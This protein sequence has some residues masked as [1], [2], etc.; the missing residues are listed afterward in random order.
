VKVL[1]GGAATKVEGILANANV[2]SARALA[3]GDES[4]GV[5]DGGA[6]AKTGTADRG[7]LLGT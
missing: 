4:E 3:T 2:A 5:F 7:G 6:L 1:D